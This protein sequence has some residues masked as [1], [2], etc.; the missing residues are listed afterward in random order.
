MIVEYIYSFH[1]HFLWNGP[2]IEGNPKQFDLFGQW[3]I[4]SLV[5]HLLTIEKKEG[6]QKLS[7]EQAA[8]TNVSDRIPQ[9]QDGTRASGQ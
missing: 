8:A 1:V 5:N 3:I 7:T 4:V 2:Y 9:S 6:A